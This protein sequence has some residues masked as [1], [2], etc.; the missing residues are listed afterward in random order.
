M[1]IM[2][3]DIQEIKARVAPLL[4]RK[5]WG[6]SLGVGSFVTLEFGEQRLPPIGK[7]QRPH[8]EWH[9]WVYCCA[10]RLEKGNEVTAGSEDPRDHLTTVIKQLDG[11]T[12]RSLEVLGPGLDS[13]FSFEN[14][15][16]LRL[17]PVIFSTEAGDYEHWFLFTPDGYVLTIGPGSAW[18]YESASR[19]P[20]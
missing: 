7:Q 8:G 14:D 6:A 9:L 16:T 13:V 5:V 12:L 15:V 3:V 18:S 1:P 10:W 2:E 4:G 17:F 11:L 20:E 19:V